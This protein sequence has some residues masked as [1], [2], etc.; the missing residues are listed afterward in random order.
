MF[1]ELKTKGVYKCFNGNSYAVTEV[2][3]ATRIK[4]SIVNS[5][6]IY[7]IEGDATITL[8]ISGKMVDFKKEELKIF[9]I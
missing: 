4:R 8:R 2:F 6:D 9:A 5:E 3:G 7:T 1:A